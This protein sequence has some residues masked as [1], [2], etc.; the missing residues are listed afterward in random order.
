MAIDNHHLTQ[1]SLAL[2]NKL[3]FKNINI[4][5]SSNN[6][7]NKGVGGGG[8]KD[9]Y[10]WSKVKLEYEIFKKNDLLFLQ[11]ILLNMFSFTATFTGVIL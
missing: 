7:N 10:Y 3:T 8:V 4:I 2:V 9:M 1:R 5:E 11:G 6:Y